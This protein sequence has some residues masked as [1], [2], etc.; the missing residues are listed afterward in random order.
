MVLMSPQPELDR[1][2]MKSRPKGTSEWAA[3][4]S[5]NK[6]MM[7]SAVTLLP[8]QARESTNRTASRHGGE[9]IADIVT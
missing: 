1:C 8:V 7:D 3:A 6:H 2:R 9:S 5:P 4:I